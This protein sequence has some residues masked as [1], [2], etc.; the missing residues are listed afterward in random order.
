MTEKAKQKL[1]HFFDKYVF[2]HWSAWYCALVI[3]FSVVVCL[4]AF[5]NCKTIEYTAKPYDLYGQPEYVQYTDAVLKGRLDLDINPS[6]ELLALENPYNPE[7]RDGKLY[8]LWD[9]AFYNGRYYCYFG[10]TPV[11]TTYLPFYFITGKMPENVTACMILAIYAVIFISLA[12]F[13]LIKRCIP[14][15]PPWLM[16]IGALSIE[17]LSGTFI[18]LA[19]SKMYQIPLIS[20]YASGFAFLFFLFRALRTE[21][22]TLQNCFLVFAG[23]CYVAIVASRPSMALCF[24]AFLPLAFFDLISGKNFKKWMPSLVYLGTPVAL[25]AVAIMWFNSARFSGPFDFGY[26]YQLTVHDCRE[27]KMSLH[28][29]PYAFIHYFLQAP[30]YEGKFPLLRASY[31]MMDYGQY[32]YVDKCYGVF[33]YPATTMSLFMPAVCSF[34]KDMGKTI[35][36]ILIPIISVFVAWTDTCLGGVHYRYVFDI[37][38]IMSILAILTWMEIVCRSKGKMKYTILFVGILLILA[39]TYVILALVFTQDNDFLF[40]RPVI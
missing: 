18:S 11:F 15:A 1:D 37:L 30:T 23:I 19:D 26:T 21:K 31:S 3:V 4:C 33:S 6:P 24:A 29:L 27:Y 9:T 5:P 38:A 17:L 39:T 20:G 32:L 7:G 2:N 8:F 35:S 40:H 10:I 14:Q 22:K 34:K 13:E 36:Y 28:M 12:S 16:A 25:G